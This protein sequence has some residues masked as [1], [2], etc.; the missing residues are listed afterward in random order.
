MPGKGTKM[1]GWLD[2]ISTWSVMKWVILVLIAGFIGQFGRMTAEAIVAKV[3]ARRNRAKQKKT[4]GT[5]TVTLAANPTASLP[6]STQLSVDEAKLEKKR[7]KA[8]AK[9]KK[10]EAANRAKNDQ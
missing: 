8:L 9:A 3:R 6:E 1:T 10:K 4:N 7:L 5:P 2:Y